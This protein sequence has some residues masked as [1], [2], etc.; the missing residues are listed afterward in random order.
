M[1]TN[2]PQGIRFSGLTKVD[3]NRSS[4]TNEISGLIYSFILDRDQIKELVENW[5]NKNEVLKNGW[6]ESLL[7]KLNEVTETQ[8]FGALEKIDFFKNQNEFQ[9]S[10]RFDKSH[11]VRIQD[12]VKKIFLIDNPVFLIKRERVI[13]N[14]SLT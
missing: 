4:M 14:K 13:F 2:L 10:V 7:D 1:N 12:I 9:L 5:I 3:S 6:S 8:E 11:P